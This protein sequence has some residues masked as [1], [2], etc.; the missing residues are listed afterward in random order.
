ML[1]KVLQEDKLNGNCSQAHV[2]SSKSDGCAAFLSNYNTRSDARVTFNNMHYD[3]PRWSISILPDCQNVVFNTAKVSEM[4]IVWDSILEGQHS[5]SFRF[6]LMWWDDKPDTISLSRLELKHLK[7][8]CCRQMW[9]CNPGRHSM[10]MYIRWRMSHH[11]LSR[12]SWNN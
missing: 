6:H 12:V 2:F 1:D 10:K 8:K 5:V 11:W 4:T 9:S 7:C 3:L